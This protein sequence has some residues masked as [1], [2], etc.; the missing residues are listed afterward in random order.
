MKTNSTNRVYLDNAATT[1][2]D[3]LVLEEMYRCEKQYG[4]VATQMHSAGREA[5]RVLSTSR[6]RIARCLGVREEEIVF[7]SG[8]TEANNIALLGAARS[9]NR[10][11]NHIITSR[12]EHPSVLG[13]CEA[14]EE[15]GFTVTRL[16]VSEEGLI[17][18]E[19]VARAINDKTILIS[20]I[21][22]EGET[23]AILPVRDIADIVRSRGIAFHTDAAQAAGKIPVHPADM[24]V[25]L[26]SLSAHKFHGPKGLGALYVRSGTRMTP[27]T[28][29]GPGPSALR[30]GTM[31]LAACAGM[32]RALELATDNIQDNLSHVTSLRDRLLEGILSLGCNVR[33]NGPKNDTL[34]LAGN[35]CLGFEGMEAEAL[36]LNLDMAGVCV[37]AGNPCVSGALEAS[38][39]LLAMGLSRSDTLSSIRFSLARDNTITDV[40]LAVKTLGAVV[41][42][43]R[44]VAV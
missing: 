19:D 15:Q 41:H 40:K 31:N 28:Y 30:P 33:L 6:A 26:L 9:Y 8:A 36:L 20:L 23:G 18:P 16:P 29:S 2:V 39:V 38:H 34:R 10:Q 32:A 35:L 7:T 27:T 43:L 25:D 4:G 13:T 1:R 44:S 21:L 17:D 42:Q 3:P 5:R 24:G 12:I 14:L 22:A 37:G 11:G